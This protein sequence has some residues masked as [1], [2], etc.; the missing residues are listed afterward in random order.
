MDLTSIGTAISL[1]GE[2]IGCVNGAATAAN[3]LR[4][5]LK[6]GKADQTELAA[7]TLDVFNQLIDAKQAQTS[8]LDRLH[9][10]ERQM[11]ALE[12]FDRQAQRYTLVTT[13]GGA[14]VYQLDPAQAKDEPAH[15][16]CPD[17]FGKKQRSILQP[18]GRFLECHCGRTFDR[19][20]PPQGGSVRVR[21]D[22][23]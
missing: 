11:I 1:A 5:L 4:Q 17:C 2:G 3:K 19:D 20:P 8:V 21:R 13:R 16:L 6:G 22:I 18:K 12:E 23:R 9:E 10:L 14:L 15:Y 7:L